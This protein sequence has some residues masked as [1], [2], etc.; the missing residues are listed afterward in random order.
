MRCRTNLNKFHFEE[1]CVAGNS[2]FASGMKCFEYLGGVP[3]VQQQII[4]LLWF[5]SYRPA[6]FTSIHPHILWTHLITGDCKSPFDPFKTWKLRWFQEESQIDFRLF[7]C[8][9]PSARICLVSRQVMTSTESKEDLQISWIPRVSF[10]CIS[11]DLMKITRYILIS[12]LFLD[13]S[14]HLPDFIHPTPNSLIFG[15]IRRQIRSTTPVW[16]WTL[17]GALP[18]P[19]ACDE[20]LKGFQPSLKAGSMALL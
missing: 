19:R 1:T 10:L 11:L 9:A 7:S 5:R 6:I 13:I 2:P 18:E 20:N 16:S 4:N 15:S 12:V 8:S 14:H 17:R 3:T